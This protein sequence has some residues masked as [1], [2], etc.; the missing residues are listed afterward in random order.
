MIGASG[1][2][3]DAVALVSGGKDS[4]FSILECARRGW[5]VIA[6]ANLHPAAGGPDELDSHLLQTVGSAALPAIAACMNVPLVRRVTAGRATHTGLSY[7]APGAIRGLDAGDEVEDLHALLADVVAAH[8]SVVAV[9]V[10]AIASTYQRLRVE[11]VCARLR[12]TPL[13]FL[14]QREQVRAT[15]GRAHAGASN[16]AATAAPRR[17][18][19][20]SSP[21]HPPNR[22]AVRPAGGHGRVGAGRRARQGGRVRPVPAPAGALRHGVRRGA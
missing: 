21:H 11:A 10:G 18:S 5:R 6:L 16:E 17:T 1:G 20:T 2:V 13:A 4:V 15:G 7:P 19:S 9:A 3:R 22:S 12:L 8:P 14:W